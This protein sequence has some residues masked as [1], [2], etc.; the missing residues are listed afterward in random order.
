MFR[1]M[2]QFHYYSRFSIFAGPSRGL[3]AAIFVS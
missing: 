1:P 2:D 3:A